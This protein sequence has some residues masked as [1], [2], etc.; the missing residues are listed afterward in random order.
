MATQGA[1]QG[2]GA[3]GAATARVIGRI[4][5]LQREK[6]YGFVKLPDG[7]EP[8]FHRSHCD[9][10]GAFDDLILDET[11]VSG[12]LAEGPD[13][14]LRIAAVQIADEATVD[15]YVDAVAQRGNRL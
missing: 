12:V 14:R 1:A 4:V 7:R 9:P 3:A 6:M 5:H 15:A 13:G 2:T 10:P 11:V 8:F